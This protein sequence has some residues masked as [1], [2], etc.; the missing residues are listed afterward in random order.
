MNPELMTHVAAPALPVNR[1][2]ARHRNQRRLVLA[3]NL[4]ATILE[5]IDTEADTAYA[6]Q[7]R[8]ALEAWDH[9]VED[10][11]VDT[12]TAQS[13]RWTTSEGAQA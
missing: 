9:A 3:G 4:M 7:V 6:R 13:G 12:V 1:R 8:Y 10:I 2:T 5:Q 11:R